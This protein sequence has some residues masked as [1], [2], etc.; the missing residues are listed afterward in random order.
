MNK[1]PINEGVG[2][3][4]ESQSCLFPATITIVFNEYT[5]SL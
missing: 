4:A 1:K 2:A 5:T 3:Y